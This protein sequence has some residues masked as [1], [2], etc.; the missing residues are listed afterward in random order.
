MDNHRLLAHAHCH[1]RN[2]AFAA[3]LLTVCLPPARAQL[4]ADNS[5]AAV[6]LI[7][8]GPYV[9]TWLPGTKAPGVWPAFWNGRV[10][11]ITGMAWIDGKPY[12]FLGAPSGQVAAMEQTRLEITPTQ[13]KFTFEAAGVD[14][15]ADFLS[16]IEAHDLRRLSMPLGDIFATARSVDGHSHDVR[17][18][19]DISAEWA[20][21]RI[22]APV[23]WSRE[24]IQPHTTSWIVSADHPAV[25]TET[26]DYPDWGDAVFATSSRSGL[27]MQAG[28]DTDVRGQFAAHGALTGTVDTEQ[29]RAVN[30]RWPVFA[31]SLSLGRVGAH[32]PL[33]FVLILGQV[34]DPAVSYLGAPVPP[35]WRSYWASTDAMLAFAC[36]DAA[37]ARTRANALDT[38][39]T[40][41]ATAAVDPAYARLVSLCLRQA[42][43]G[44]ELVGTPDHPWLMLKEISSDGNVSTVDVIY[45]GMPAF[46]ALDPRLLR[47]L[48][49]PLLAYAESGRWPQAFAEH[50][51]GASYPN[52]GAHDD[53]G[54]ENMPVEESA[55]MLIM[56]A[57]Y[58]RAAPAADSSAYS[59]QHYAV[60]RKWGE[61]LLATPPGTAD[62]NALDPQFQNQTDDFTGPIAHSVNLALKGIIAVGAMGEIAGIAGQQ[63]DAARYTAAS[64]KLIAEWARRA[65]STDGRHLLLQYREPAV[66]GSPDTTLEPDSAWSLKYNAF[67]DRLLGLHLIPHAVL[68]EESAADRPRLTP[69]G[70]PLDFRH[71]YTKADWE[72]WTAASVDD[73]ALTRALVDAVARYADS[74]PSGAPLPDWYDPAGPFTGFAARPVM[75]AA[76]APLLTAHH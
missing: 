70:L 22:D 68:D 23:R 2:L 56:T 45:P 36:A 38:G 34:R 17:L 73:P 40:A 52:A 32:A 69:R 14:I 28:A 53:G 57:A 76:L 30:D 33:P 64:R 8:R 21:G 1:L 71:A 5:P 72:L 20:D 65:Q 59:R 24:T 3:I 13:S 74:A 16:P 4:P 60:L 44:T 61:Y 58:L 26:A 7:V 6:P 27:A 37:G 50:D 31:Y 35:L 39:L 10:K 75:G 47:L 63:V 9:S 67:A 42:V 48:L 51:L 12:L 54:G 41:S 49:D 43:G 46:L 66:A 15:D 18:Y 11:A 62:S 19:F 29:P 25:L 55:D